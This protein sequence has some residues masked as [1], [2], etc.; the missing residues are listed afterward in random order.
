MQQH[1]HNSYL[2][3]TYPTAFSFKPSI[4][5]QQTSTDDTS[6]KSLSSQVTGLDSTS[7][8]DVMKSDGL[9]LAVL[10]MKFRLYHAFRVTNVMNFPHTEYIHEPNT[11]DKNALQR[12]MQ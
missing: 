4:T 10:S 12:K 2:C 9:N 6:T 7:C 1:R 11:D 8:T 3:L 5:L